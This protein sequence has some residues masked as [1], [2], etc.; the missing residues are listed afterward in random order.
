MNVEHERLK[1]ILAEAAGKETPE[2]RVAYLDAACQGDAALRQQVEAL[3]AAH[4]RAGDFLEQSVI[5]PAEKPIGEGPGTRIGRYKLLEKIGEGGFGVVF[6]AEQTE[7]VN[8]KVALKIIKAGMDTREVIARFEAERQALALMDH[9][10]IARVLDAD[11]TETGRP[12]FVMELVNGI[13]ITDYSDQKQLSTAERLQ[14]FM[15][16]CAAVQHAH[17]KG[18]IHRDLKPTNILVTVIAGEAVPKVIDF[19]VAKALGQKLTQKTLFTAF[20]QMI[21]TPAYMSPEQ[22]ALSGVDVDT[23]SDIYALGV[24]LYELLTGVTPFDAETL[25]QSAL[26]EMRRL[27]RETEPPKPSTRLTE[28]ARSQKSEVGNQK[29]KEVHGDLDWIVMKCLEKDRTRRYET[30]NSLATDIQHYLTDEPVMARPPGRLYRFHKLVRRNKLAFAATGAVSAALVIGLGLSTWS[31][32]REKAARQRAVAAEAAQRQLRQQA[33]ANEKKAET[34][35]T[36]SRQVA[37]F[38]KDMLN[39]VG[40]SVAL[41]RDTAM[42]REILDKTAQRVNDLKGQTAVKADLHAT[43]GNV[44]CELGEYTNAA[45]MHLSALALRKKLLGGEHPEVANSLNNLAEVFYQQGKWADAEATHREALVMRK[46]LLGNTHPDVAASLNNLAETLRR[47][48]KHAESETIQR[49]ALAM[50]RKLLGNEHADVAASLHSLAVLLS[51][52]GRHPDAEPTCREALSMRRKLLGKEHPGVATTLEMLGGVLL[53]QGKHDEAEQVGREALAMRKKLLGDTHPDVGRSLHGLAFLLRERGKLAE[54]EALYRDALIMKRKLLGN[55]HPDVMDTLAHLARMSVLQ[56]NLTEAETGFRQA[57]AIRD[58]LNLG[59][60]PSLAFTEF[61]FGNLLVQLGKWAEA[62]TWYREALAMRRKLSGDNDLAVANALAPLTLTLLRQ[63]K[64]AAAEPLARE[65]LALRE[66]KIPGHWLTF[67]TRS[68]PG[69]SLLGQK[70][71]AEAEPLLLAGY[72]GMQQREDKI[73]ANGKPRLHEALQ[74]LVQL[75]ESTGRP[76]QAAE[77]K[78]KLAEIE[79]AQT[80]Q[81]PAAPLR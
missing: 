72:E 46:K 74:R 37:Q 59:H 11:A 25:R 31:F 47:E 39:G 79:K 2:A 48:G 8:R 23:R 18:I 73:P 12:Y 17:Q 81:K 55:E 4:A 75:Y 19:G 66:K 69:S 68:L 76:D 32:F 60:Q 42:L 77:W 36:K 38:L 43:L 50:R 64:F 24:L 78:Q 56:G 15:K 1:E 58:K 21:G 34:E 52:Q 5:P 41:G 13:P 7:P 54:A 33:E 6:M 63:E 27:I 29:W 51:D 20:Q 22:A 71:N 16:V 35:A 62:E 44:Y 80:E 45:A 3:L 30:A 14:L 49:E 65:C 61:L 40:P 53:S 9:P 57:L 26:D 28:L 67:D 70:K 10:N